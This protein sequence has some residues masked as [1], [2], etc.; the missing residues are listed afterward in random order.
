M[1]IKQPLPNNQWVKE[2]IR[3]EIKNY[4]ETNENTKYQNL[5]DAAKAIN[6]YDKNSQQ[7]G[8]RGN[9]PQHNKG[10]I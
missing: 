10:H 5:R 6:F 8:Y 7:S 1:E 2:E 3:R 4:L 9:R